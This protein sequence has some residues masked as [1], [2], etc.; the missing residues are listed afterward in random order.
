MGRDV[1]GNLIPFFVSDRGV[2]G[3]DISTSRA[4]S[5]AVAFTIPRPRES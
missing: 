4:L 5:F 2:S 1:D 3:T